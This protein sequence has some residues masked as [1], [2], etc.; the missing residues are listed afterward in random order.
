MRINIEDKLFS[1]YR[2]HNLKK[3]LGSEAEALLLCYRFWRVACDHYGQ[4][5]PM[6]AVIVKHG[7]FEP[8]VDVGL[9]EVVDGELFAKGAQDQFEW[10]RQKLDAAQ[11]GGKKSA[12]R[13]RDEKGRLLPARTVVQAGAKRE[14]SGSQPESS[15][16]APAPAPAP[17]DEKHHR[18][19]ARNDPE[20]KEDGDGGFSGSDP[21]DISM[22]DEPDSEEAGRWLAIDQ[23]ALAS[24]GARPVDWKGLMKLRRIGATPELVQQRIA[25]FVEQATRGKYHGAGIRNPTGLLVAQIAAQ[26]GGLTMQPSDVKLANS[27]FRDAT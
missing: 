7:G 6:P 14:P 16:P 8:L 4:R 23:S 20:R 10:Y 21:I 27:A 12:T 25:W 3:I 9:A 24:V 19:R 15:P 2:F 18:A 17:K 26:I 11:K 5:K 22:K 13:P 1:D